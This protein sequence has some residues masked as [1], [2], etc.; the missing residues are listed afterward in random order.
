MGMDMTVA[1]SVTGLAKY[2]GMEK[3]PAGDARCGWGD[4][5]PLICPDRWS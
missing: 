5:V 1:A 3:G 2:M 4:C